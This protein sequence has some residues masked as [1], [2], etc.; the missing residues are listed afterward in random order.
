LADE[1]GVRY[2]LVMSTNGTEELVLMV[3]DE[4][5]Q[6]GVRSVSPVHPGLATYLTRDEAREVGEHLITFADT[7][8]L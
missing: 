1:S 7:R 2:D 5:L 6:V 3:V 4:T 8:H